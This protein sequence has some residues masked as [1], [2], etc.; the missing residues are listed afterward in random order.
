MKIKTEK[1]IS[2]GA[3]NPRKP[4]RAFYYCSCFMLFILTLCFY[5]RYY[6]SLIVYYTTHT[7]T[8]T[9]FTSK[10]S[11]LFHLHVSIIAFPFFFFSSFWGFFFW[12]SFQSRKNTMVNNSLCDRWSVVGEI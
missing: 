11:Y 8:H 6:Y 1:H 12:D 3:H 7:H 10:N 4:T 2:L 5:Y 9:H